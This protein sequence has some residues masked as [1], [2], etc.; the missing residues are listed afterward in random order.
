MRQAKITFVTIKGGCILMN[1]NKQS[2]KY[3]LT[4]NNPLP[5]YP[6]DKII[7]ILA[8][9]FKSFAYCAMADEIGLKE[10]TPHTHIFVCFSSGVR[11]NT[12][13]NQ[14]PTAHIEFTRGSI[15]QNISYI[16]KTEK[17][18]ETEK[19][20]TSI[21]G[22]F[23]E[24]GNR[25]PENEGKLF[26]MERLY[27]MIVEDE[28]SNAEILRTNNDY[29]LQIDKLDKIR[30]TYLQDKFKGTR[31]LNLE[32]TYV[33]GVTGTGKTKNIL[34]EHGDEHVYRVTDYKHPFDGYTTEDVLVFEEFRNSLPLKDMLNYLDIYPI[35]LSARYANKYA[36]YT[37]IYICT[38]WA[39][40]KQYEEEQRNDQES[41]NA[42]L[43][44]IH[45]VKEYGKNGIIEYPNTHEYF[46]SKNK[47]VPKNELPTDEQATIDTI[48]P[49]DK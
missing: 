25:P 27:Q 12:I 11:F 24:Y 21:K 34:D 9:K 14:F 7:E 36:C 40:E 47:F 41:W 32:V 49:T 45:K 48:F 19:A 38:N 29:I 1:P 43:R 44:R 4:I 18:A 31:R 16:Q 46:N 17:W 42:L 37:K 28:M 5:D 13:K 10:K 39:L 30:T 22:S 35:Q 15:Q 6:H 26:E 8:T 33:Y 2:R 23:E 20:E 3:Q